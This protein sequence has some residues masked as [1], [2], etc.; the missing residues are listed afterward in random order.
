MTTFDNEIKQK[1]CFKFYYEICD[2]ETCKKSSFNNHN[3]SKKHKNN[4]MTTNNNENYAQNS[5]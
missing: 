4:E 5:K 1:L 3:E 2:Y